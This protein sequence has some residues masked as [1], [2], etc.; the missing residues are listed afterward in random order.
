MQNLPPTLS[1]R[2]FMLTC[3]QLAVLFAPC[4][5]G[6]QLRAVAAQAATQP[7]GYG[8]GA[9]GQAV[10]KGTVNQIYLPLV[11]NKGE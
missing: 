11:S 9:Y 7:G 10:Y 8:T 5:R 3:G 4:S 2:T 1:R 6:Y